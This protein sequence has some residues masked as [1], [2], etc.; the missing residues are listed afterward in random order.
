MR[1]HDLIARG[2]ATARQRRE[3][4][5]EE[6]ARMLRFHGLTSWR[7]STVGSL[8]SGLRRPRLE[9]L[10]LICAATGC[11]LEELLPDC[12]ERIELGEGASMTPLAIR[13][14]LDGS[15]SD[16]PDDFAVTQMSFPGEAEVAEVYA[17]SLPELERVE[18]LLEPIRDRH[19]GELTHGD[20]AAAW[21]PPTDPER[22]A[23]KRLGAEAPQI[24]LEARALWHRDFAEERDA[25]IGSDSD[26]QGLGPRTLQARRGLVTRDLL[27]E[28]RTGL[29]ADYAS[30][31]KSEG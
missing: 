11:T 22:Y 23:A 2:F 28:L 21:Q 5:Q 18:R 3:L 25:R 9:E 19:K 26:L 10:V 6:A 13:A 31:E 12:S 16:W 20:W 8:E 27:A 1:M 7:T 29:D 24:K 14:V 15:A 17:N 30:P 4:T